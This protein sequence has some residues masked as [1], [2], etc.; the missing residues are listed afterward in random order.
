MIP[1]KFFFLAVR[2]E[3]SREDIVLQWRRDEETKVGP[4]KATGLQK[5]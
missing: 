3:L 2:L 5:K 1:W 4:K